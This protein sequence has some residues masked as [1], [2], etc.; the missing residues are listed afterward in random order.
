MNFFLIVVN[1]Y[2]SATVLCDWH[3]KFLG[4]KDWP[5]QLG[6]HVQQGNFFENPEASLFI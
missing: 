2:L 1:Y 4:E 5:C 6:Q 3:C